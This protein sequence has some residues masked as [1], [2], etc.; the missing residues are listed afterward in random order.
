MGWR[1]LTLIAF[2][3]FAGGPAEGAPRSPRP[4]YE[5]SVRSTHPNAIARFDNREWTYRGDTLAIS[6]RN[7]T[8][9]AA[10]RQAYRVC[11]TGRFGQRCRSRTLTGRARDVWRMRLLDK[12]VGYRGKRYVRYIEFRWRVGSRTVAKRRAWIWE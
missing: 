8:A 7:A 11:W 2:A 3:L 1:S 4:H 9:V 6:F 10:A 5:A 12:W